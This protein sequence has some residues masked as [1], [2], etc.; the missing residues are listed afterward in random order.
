MGKKTIEIASTAVVEENVEI[1]VGSKIM[2]GAYIS[3]D[4]KIGKN[5]FDQI[6]VIFMAIGI[7]LQIF[8]R[9]ICLRTSCFKICE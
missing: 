7:Y 9:N 1:G 2:A 6:F 4:V 3:K 8:R 5:C